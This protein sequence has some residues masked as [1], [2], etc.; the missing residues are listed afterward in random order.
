VDAVADAYGEEAVHDR[1]MANL[2]VVIEER[3]AELTRETRE[4]E[5]SVRAGRRRLGDLIDRKNELIAQE[6]AHRLV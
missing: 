4:H 2:N 5:V 6:A 1:E 3:L